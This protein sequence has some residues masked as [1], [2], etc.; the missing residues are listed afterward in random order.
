M[1]NEILENPVAGAI[2]KSLK[3]LELVAVGQLEGAC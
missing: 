2:K 1:L 3:A